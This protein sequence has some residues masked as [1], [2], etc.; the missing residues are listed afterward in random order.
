MAPHELEP[1]ERR[2]QIVKLLQGKEMR[3]SEI[4]ESFDVDE[5]TIRT[6]LQALREGLDVFG[7]KIQIESKHYDGNPKQYYKSTVHPV[8]LALNSSE[9]FALLRLLENAR[10]TNTG[11]VYNQIFHQ[12][13][14]QVTDYFEKLIDGKLK[15]KYVKS[16][17][18]NRLEEDAYKDYED[19]KLMYWV[20]SGDFLEIS[21]NNETSESI[22]EEMQLIKLPDIEN[23]IVLR[24]RRQ[25]EH[26]FY[27]NDIVIDW[28]KA[29]YK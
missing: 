25:N 21:Y 14:S 20:K 27:L 24:D 28:T 6:D 8:M 7:I 23:K 9:L 10:D 16:E 18:K 12:V 5:R 29:T 1:N 11:E 4:A 15:N 13:Y 22:T 17:V 2:I 26:R 19:Y 3:T